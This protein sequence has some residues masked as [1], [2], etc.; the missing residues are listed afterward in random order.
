VFAVSPVRFAEIEVGENPVTEVGV[1]DKLF[2]KLPEDVPHRNTIEEVVNE[3]AFTLPFSVT[4]FVPRAVT[5][6]VVTV[7]ESTKVKLRI[8]PK[9][10][11]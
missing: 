10:V 1:P 5:D 6:V 11:P 4:E 2:D 7:G 9:L 3:L 8:L